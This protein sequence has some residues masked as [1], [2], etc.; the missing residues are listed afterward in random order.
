MIGDFRQIEQAIKSQLIESLHVL[1]A[2]GYRV[3]WQCNFIVCQGVENIS[4]VGAG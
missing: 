1:K 3:T 4:I 2:L